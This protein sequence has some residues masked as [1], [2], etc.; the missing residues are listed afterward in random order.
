M[1]RRRLVLVGPIAF[2]CVALASGIGSPGCGAAVAPAAPEASVGDGDF[3]DPPVYEVPDGA[4][5]IRCDDGGAGAPDAPIAC[6]PP[7]AEHC[8]GPTRLVSYRRVNDTCDPGGRCIYERLERSCTEIGG[9]ACVL[10]DSGPLC[11][12]LVGK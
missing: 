7:P 1:A 2:A 4:V 6:A 11:P 9:T 10:T 12:Q 8:E 5:V 3:V